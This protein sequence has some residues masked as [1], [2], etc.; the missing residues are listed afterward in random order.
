MMASCSQ[1]VDRFAELLY[2][3]CAQQMEDAMCYAKDYNLFD[4]QKK[5]EDTQVV[6]ERRASLIDRLLNAANKQDAKAGAPVK[7]VAPAK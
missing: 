3:W 6:K 2:G 1:T 4:D 5:A 7:E